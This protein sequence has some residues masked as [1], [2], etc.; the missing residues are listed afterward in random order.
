MFKIELKVSCLHSSC[1]GVGD[2]LEVKH[3]EEVFAGV[4][5]GDGVGRSEGAGGQGES[6]GGGNERLHD[7]RN[8]DADGQGIPVDRCEEMGLE[9]SKIPMHRAFVPNPL[10]GTLSYILFHMHT[11]TTSLAPDVATNT[12]SHDV[13]HRTDAQR[14]MS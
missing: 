14:H 5:V 2:G 1:C 7:G 4:R 8:K 11:K 6:G 13:L 12:A 10:S 3:G 9:Y